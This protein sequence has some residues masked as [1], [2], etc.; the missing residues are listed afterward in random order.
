M[1]DVTFR[2]RAHR[3]AGIP[4]KQPFRFAL[5][6]LGAITLCDRDDRTED[7]T[8][9]PLYRTSDKVILFIHIPKTGGST[10]EEV[11]AVSGAAQA[12]KYHK[13]L[14]Y[15]SSTPQH[16]A[17]DVIQ[18]WL[19]QGFY[20]YAFTLVR[21][22]VA[23]LVSEYRWRKSLSETPLPDFD[24][25]VKRQLARYAKNNYILDNH[26]RPQSEFIGPDV[27]VFRLEDGIEF[28]I[29]AG[30]D[31]LGL[32]ADDIEIHHARRSETSPLTVTA[33]TLEDIRT[34]YA[35]DFECFGYDPATIPGTLKV[36]DPAP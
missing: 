28:P 29:Y 30:L 21:N 25:W 22:P 10:V 36:D 18:Y 13:R 9:M 2:I 23:R 31:Q 14:G 19:P 6:S 7:R 20:D 34:F 35:A 17:W 1:T 26:I 11:L 4:Q 3:P 15:S 27:E 12:L 33:Q 5:N 24:T 32:H 16:M 8:R